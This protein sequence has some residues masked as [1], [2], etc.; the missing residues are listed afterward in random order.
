MSVSQGTPH[1]FMPSLTGSSSASG[2][3]SSVAK[4]RSRCFH[5]KYLETCKKRNAAPVPEIKEKEKNVLDFIA[6][7]V[8]L[9]DWPSIMKALIGDDGALRGLG[10]RLR[11]A[12]TH[13][14]CFTSIIFQLIIYVM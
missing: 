1:S 13:G 2:I 14:W 6:D 3:T 8:K 9:D 10:I 5:R 12:Y 11:K 7:R 4:R